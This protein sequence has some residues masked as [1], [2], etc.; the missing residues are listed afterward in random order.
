M[1]PV[2]EAAWE[3]FKEWID[4]ARPALDGCVPV[5]LIAMPFDRPTRRA[6]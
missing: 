3:Q 4:R 6:P 5:A 1:S 2:E